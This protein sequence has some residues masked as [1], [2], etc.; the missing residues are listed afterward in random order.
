[1][2]LH[3]HF[4]EDKKRNENMTTLKDVSP[5]AQFVSEVFPPEAEAEEDTPEAE[6]EEAPKR[7]GRPKKSE[8]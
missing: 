5:K 4:E 2:M 8:E 6:A 3:R 7:R 1:M